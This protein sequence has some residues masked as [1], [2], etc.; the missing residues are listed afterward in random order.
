M[1]RKSMLNYKETC[2]ILTDAVQMTSDH[3]PSY[4][5][6]LSEEGIN[7]N[8]NMKT[9]VETNYREWL[10]RLNGSKPKLKCKGYCKIDDFTGSQLLRVFHD[11]I[12]KKIG[13]NFFYGPGDVLYFSKN[14]SICAAIMFTYS[15]L[16]TTTPPKEKKLARNDKSVRSN[17][18][19]YSKLFNDDY[20]KK[21]QKKRNKYR[22]DY[23]DENYM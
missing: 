20:V 5:I 15:K 13:K 21:F 11:I 9:K 1:N 17:K 22:Q 2:K 4:M 23:C 3:F 8:D 7:D 19:L 14:D 12:S 10:K 18:Q 16:L 6:V